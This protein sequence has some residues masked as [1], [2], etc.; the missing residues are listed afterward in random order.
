MFLSY[1]TLSTSLSIDALGVGLAYG[2][3]RVRIPIRSKL[4]ICFFSI[5]YS[6]I[7]LF[8]GKSL[9]KIIPPSVSGYLGV[10]IL[11][12]MGITLVTKVILNNKDESSINSDSNNED[13]TLY[14]AVVRSL[15]ITIQIIKNPMKGDI[16][17]SGTIDVLE[18]IMLGLALSVDSIGV[19]IGSALLGFYSIGIPLCVGIFQLMFLSFGLYIGDK[20][21]RRKNVNKDAL[22]LLP[23]MLLICLALA[24]IK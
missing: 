17:K 21:N 9:A 1:I 18:S 22:E 10:V 6:G 7:S 5:I 8:L 19:G 14:K 11:F 23:G 3:N 15:G 13:K 2:I 24:R 16:D 20:L 12:A 4:I